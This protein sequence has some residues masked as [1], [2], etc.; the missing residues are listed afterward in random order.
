MELGNEG[1]AKYLTAAILVA[2]GVW[3]FFDSFFWGIVAGAA[4]YYLMQRD[5]DQEDD[6]E[7]LS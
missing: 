5:Q 1:E 2:L 3:L 6:G 4:T 7:D